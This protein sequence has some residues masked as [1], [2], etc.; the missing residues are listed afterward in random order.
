MGRS[1]A[2]L[3]FAAALAAD[4]SVIVNTSFGKL[5]GSREYLQGCEKFLGIPFAKAPVGS[6]RFE[7]PV[8]WDEAYPKEGMQAKSFSASCPQLLPS[9]SEDCL[10]L[11]VWRPAR[12][13]TESLPVIAFIYGG[14]FISGGS[15]ASILG[16]VPSVL[17]LYDGCGFVAKQDIVVATLNYRL[18]VLG[19]AAFEE[20]GKYSGNFAM[21]DQREA[22]KW[23]QREL[24]AFGG[25]PKKVTI[26]GE[27]AGGMSVFYHVASPMSKGLFRGAISD[28]GFPTAWPWEKGRDVTSSLAAKLGCTE[29]GALKACL[30]KL[31]QKWLIGNQTCPPGDETCN[32]TNP[33]DFPT[34]HPPWQPVV[35]GSDMPRYPFSLIKDKQTNAVPMLAGSNTNESNLFV[36]PF[37]EK[38]MNNSQF[39]KYFEKGVLAN[40]AQPSSPL[41][42]SEKAE[43]LAIYTND[44]LQLDG[45]DK[46]VLA[47]Q[48]ATDVSFQCGTHVSGQ[49]H[50]NDFWLY[51]FNHRSACQFWLD[52]LM[53]GVYHTAE[54]QYIFDARAKLACILTPHEQALS[55]R[56]QA[57]WAN[58]AKCLD[59]T[60]GGSS[61]PKFTNS[62]RKALVLQTPA[63]VIEEDYASNRC[64]LW[65]Q[66]I[67]ERY[68]GQSGGPSNLENLIV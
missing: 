6:L 44:K 56:M 28:S 7:D 1:V 55:D 14:G 23:L 32:I 68:R 15:S 65:D 39:E 20:N 13:H 30:R 26:F 51:R 3:L 24:P 58:F 12:S 38:G 67:Y 18:G 16:V 4:A 21:K 61:W 37:Y 45:D 34:A 60:C 66:L 43:V 10:F 42:D 40:Y 2:L 57:M 17:N 29:P 59:P 62:T 54:L 27:S 63:D 9:G 49:E 35:D 22:L 11:N 46:R 47:S 31:P 48:I 52:K 50:V 8:P 36:W 53:P 64:A 19:F 33:F 41:K 25:D 5:I